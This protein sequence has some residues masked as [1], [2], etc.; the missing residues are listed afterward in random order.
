ME[1]NFNL[2]CSDQ[3]ITIS[4]N[5]KDLVVIISCEGGD[6]SFHTKLKASDQISKY[7]SSIIFGISDFND[8]SV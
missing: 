8:K 2:G 7:S 3:I 6:F 5:E 4:S 1:I